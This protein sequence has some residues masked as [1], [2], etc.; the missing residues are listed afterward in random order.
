ME[1]LNKPLF[2]IAIILTLPIWLVALVV[3]IPFA[4]LRS[5]LG[6]PG[7]GANEEEMYYNEFGPDE[8]D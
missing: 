2:I 4:L 6:R 5:V 8:V 3:Y 1:R 7:S